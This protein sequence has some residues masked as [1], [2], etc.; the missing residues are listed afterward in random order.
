MS[1]LNTLTTLV[2]AGYPVWYAYGVSRGVIDTSDGLAHELQVVSGIISESENKNNILRARDSW[3]ALSEDERK[4]RIQEQNEK[5]NQEQLEKHTQ[6]LEKHRQ[7]IENYKKEIIETEKKK[8]QFYKDTKGDHSI[9]K[10]KIVSEYNTF[11][12]NKKK[13]I[14]EESAEISKLIRNLPSTS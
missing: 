7:N 2:S 8:E 6:N 11:I 5:K 1:R 13:K 14:K 9:E 12:E 4:K 3:N 10:L